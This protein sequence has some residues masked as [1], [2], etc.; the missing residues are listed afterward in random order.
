M[1]YSDDGN[2]FFTR[3]LDA[4][5]RGD[6]T[7]RRLLPGHQLFQVW[8]AHRELAARHYNL[9]TST[10]SLDRTSKAVAEYQSARSTSPGLEGSGNTKPVRT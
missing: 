8:P 1:S 5:D 10:W 7:W 3:A 6:H 9:G 4:E 2:G